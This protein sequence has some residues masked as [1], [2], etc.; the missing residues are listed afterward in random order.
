MNYKDLL[1]QHRVIPTQRLLLRPCVLEDTESVYAIGSH[2]EVLKTL[3]W[4]GFEN[5]GD[6]TH[7][8]LSYYPSCD[9]YWCFEE[10]EGEGVVGMLE[11][12]LIP[13]HEKATF[14]YML[15]P[16]AWGKG[17]MTE[18]LQAI[19]TFSFSV[20]GLNRLEGQNITENPASGRVMEKAGLYYEGRAIEELKIQGQF[21][22][23]DKYGLTKAQWKK[24]QKNNKA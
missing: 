22:S 15:H 23:L 10:R 17:Y 20:L 21:V 4:P 2:P 18:A 1:E 11:F 24:M 19:V 12:R 6:A 5:Q 16:K 8:I 7:A 9:G 14:S 3:F 13:E